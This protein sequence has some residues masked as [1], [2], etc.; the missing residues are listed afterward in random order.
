MGVWGKGPELPEDAYAL[1]RLHV[2]QSGGIPCRDKHPFPGPQ[3]SKPAHGMGISEGPGLLGLRL[4]RFTV[5]E[6]ELCLLGK[7][8]AA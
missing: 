4:S 6:N 3:E 2:R 7:G 1:L 8:D 5:S